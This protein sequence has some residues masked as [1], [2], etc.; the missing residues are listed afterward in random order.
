MA[1][2]PMFRLRALLLG[3]WRLSLDRRTLER[4]FPVMEVR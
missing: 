3:T 4:E 1:A 2:S